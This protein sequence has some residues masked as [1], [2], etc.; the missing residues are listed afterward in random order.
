M[1][2]RAARVT[3]VFCIAVVLMA[4]IGW[5]DEINNNSRIQNLEVDLLK[6]A[7][8]RMG[9]DSAEAMD[10]Y[11][12]DTGLQQQIINEA[13][14]RMDAD[15]TE[16]AARNQ[17]DADLQLQLDIEAQER[18]EADSAEA[19]ARI[20]GD[21]D[22]KLQIDT[23]ELIPGPA[24]PI[25]PSGPQGIQG[26]PGPRGPLGPPG[27]TG[28]ASSYIS[29]SFL[30]GVDAWPWRE[31][32]KV[33]N[34][35]DPISGDLDQFANADTSVWWVGRSAAYSH[36]SGQ[37]VPIYLPVQL[38]DGA[39]VVKFGILYYDETGGDPTKSLAYLQRTRGDPSGLRIATIK[40]AGGSPQL[41][42]AWTTNINPDRA[43][44][45]N[46]TQGYHIRANLYGGEPTAVLTAFVAYEMGTPPTGGEDPPGGGDVD[47]SGIWD[48]VENIY[49]AQCLDTGENLFT[50]DISHVG[51]DVTLY[52]PEGDTITLPLVGN[53]VTEDEENGA[54]SFHLAITFTSV[55]TFEGE[56]VEFWEDGN[57]FQ[58]L[59]LTG[60][61]Q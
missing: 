50:L 27:G 55:N 59:T 46:S 18:M 51:N 57:C 34:I 36:P 29:V 61:R 41:Q 10:R 32:G 60:S 19:A 26:P 49:E 38:P 58:K 33:T 23:I 20:Q 48:V 24:G 3:L 28:S 47:Y 35:W 16:A 44:I 21:A 7:E 17:G 39:V 40:R 14:Q 31:S 37:Y 52:T 43:V 53:T 45:D 54:N 15:S 1:W 9:A 42:Y 2:Y 22:L 5:A 12:G 25:G 30:P 6:E 56:L 8:A 13:Q 4:G 11:L